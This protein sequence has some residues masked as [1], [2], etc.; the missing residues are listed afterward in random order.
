M[1]RKP[2]NPG[3]GKAPVNTPAS[4]AGWGGPAKGAGSDAPTRAT[5]PKFAPGNTLGG[6]PGDRAALRRAQHEEHL[7]LL[8][9]AALG[10]KRIDPVQ[11]KAAEVFRDSTVG[12]PRQTQVN[13]NGDVAEALDGMR[14]RRGPET[15][16]G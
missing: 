4:G 15:G 7:D 13:I 6:G 8:Y 2:R 3:T 12:P 5:G 9:L 16:G 1:P 11:V 10:K 14:R